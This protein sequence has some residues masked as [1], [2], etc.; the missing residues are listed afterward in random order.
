VNEGQLGDAE[1]LKPGEFD[2]SVD[3]RFEQRLVLNAPSRHNRK[4]R[5]VI[6]L[7]NADDDLYGLWTAA[8]VNVTAPST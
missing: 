2:R 5:K 4:L 6:D 8:N 1:V 7:V 3:E